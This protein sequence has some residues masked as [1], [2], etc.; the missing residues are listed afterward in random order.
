MDWYKDFHLTWQVFGFE[1]SDVW[2]MNESGFMVGMEKNQKV[3]MK[4]PPQKLYLGSSTNRE[5]VTV[6]EAISA[7]GMENH[8]SNGDLTRQAL[9]RMLV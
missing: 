6:V 7:G 5:L 9:P 3:I 4:D 2:N 8:S 1:S